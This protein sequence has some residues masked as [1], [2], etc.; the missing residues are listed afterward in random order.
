MTDRKYLFDDIFL[1]HQ[2]KDLESGNVA[3][4]SLSPLQNHALAR[5][6][7][8]PPNAMHGEYI[9]DENKELTLACW[10]KMG[11]ILWAFGIIWIVNFG[12]LG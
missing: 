1:L 4:K 3:W 8:A 11:I 6:Y 5:D 7:S 12:R 9:L 2:K 10:I